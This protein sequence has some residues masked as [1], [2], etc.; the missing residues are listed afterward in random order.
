MLTELRMN[1]EAAQRARALSSFAP[2]QASLAVALLGLGLLLWFSLDTIRALHPAWLEAVDYSHGY[3]VLLMTVWLLVIELRR[4]PLAPFVP[5][6]P[7]VV[8]FFALVLATLAGRAATTSWGAAATFPALW[9]AAVWAAAG[10]TNAR[11]FAPR[12]AYLYFAM[13]IWTFLVEP[14]RRLTVYVVTSWIRAADMPAFI[15]GNFIHVP[16][17]SFE[18]QGGCAGLRYAIV[19]LALAAFANLLSRRRWGPASCC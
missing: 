5:S 12:L 4:E 3:L 2:A 18:V 8:C 17:G 9:I 13:P 19:S 14:L 16:S 6:W 10:P 7:G 15:D 1:G 11:R